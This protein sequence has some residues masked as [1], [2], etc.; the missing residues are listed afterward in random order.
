MTLMFVHKNEGSSELKRQMNI[1]RSIFRSF[2]SVASGD[3]DH[4]WWHC[5]IMNRWYIF[6]LQISISGVESFSAGFLAIFC[7][8]KFRELRYPSERWLICLCFALFAITDIYLSTGMIKNFWNCRLT[9][10]LKRQMKTQ[11][12]IFRWFNS[13]ASSD[14]DH[15]WW[16]CAF[17][18]SWYI[19]VCRFRES[20]QFRQDFWQFFCNPKFKELRYPSER[21]L[22]SLLRSVCNYWYLT[23]QEWFKISGT[24]VKHQGCIFVWLCPVGHNF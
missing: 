24:F 3:V 13:I 4:S 15:S 10:V 7:K 23:T 1:Q 11:G 8:A 2:S 9:S 20:D 14:V 5:A 17:F 6:C 16:H 22:I 18:N 19:S 21:W 12:S